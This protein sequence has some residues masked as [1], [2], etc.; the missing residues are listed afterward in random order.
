MVDDQTTD[1]LVVDEQM[2]QEGDETYE[3][4]G[5]E[6]TVKKDEGKVNVSSMSPPL[7]VHRNI[8]GPGA[9]LS[10]WHKRLGVSK[11]RIGLMVKHGLV[12]GLNIKG[13]SPGCDRTCTC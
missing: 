3:G 11:L 2:S 9:S 7:S 8:H 13:R 4:S 12:L 5:K 6:S 10:L 1:K